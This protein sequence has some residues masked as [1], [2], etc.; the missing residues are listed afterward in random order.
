MTRGTIEHLPG[1]LNPLEDPKAHQRRFDELA[2]GFTQSELTRQ[3]ED[4]S[5][6]TIVAYRRHIDPLNHHERAAV[7]EFRLRAAAAG[8]REAFSPLVLPMQATVYGGHEYIAT[9]DRP[10]RPLTFVQFGYETTPT[11]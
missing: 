9:E 1:G 10:T 2:V 6:T 5:R 11:A 3:N 4:G 8:M 7:E